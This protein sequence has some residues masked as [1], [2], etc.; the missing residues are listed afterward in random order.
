VHS[1]NKPTRKR[2]RRERGQALLEFA[3]VVPIFLVLVFG[4]VDFGWALKTWIT[5]TNSARE[6]AR[7]G[8][9]GWAPGTYPTNCNESAADDITVV[10]RTCST[11]AAD[12]ADLR[13]VSA[14]YEEHNGVP[15]VQ[16][17]DSVVVSMT[18]K[19]DFI[20]PLGSFI[21][22][23]IKKDCGGVEADICFHGH[24]DMR[25]E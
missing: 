15:G 6:G 7:F 11:L 20:T 1:K 23:W 18:Y 12:L 2:S 24:A 22:G 16:T 17:G 14:T 9:V 21:G 4:I 19:Y 13:S 3:L 8:A 5:V 10:G 25:V